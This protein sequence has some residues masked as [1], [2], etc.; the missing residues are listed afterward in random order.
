M[1]VR[2]SSFISNSHSFGGAIYFQGNSDLTIVGSNFTQNK[3]FLGGSIYVQKVDFKQMSIQIMDCTFSNNSVN[4]F[5][6]YMSIEYFGGLGGVLCF[7]LSG[8]A[9]QTNILVSRNIFI[10]NNASYTEGAGGTLYGF[11]GAIYIRSGGYF[12]LTD[13]IFQ[14]NQADTIGGCVYCVGSSQF[15]SKGNTFAQNGFMKGS[16]MEAK[17]GAVAVENTNYIDENNTYTS[18]HSPSVRLLKFYI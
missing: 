6:P 12:A 16:F 18:K 17:G 7:D 13:N 5:R 1:I 11:G 10:G 3:A 4:G 9:N 15:S 2:H 8:S 14:A